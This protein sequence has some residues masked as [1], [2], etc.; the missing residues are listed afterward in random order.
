[1]RSLMRVGLPVA[2][3]RV[4]TPQPKGGACEGSAETLLRFLFSGESGMVVGSFSILGHRM[5]EARG[6]SS[7]TRGSAAR[8]YHFFAGTHAIPKTAPAP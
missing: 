4:G 5:R 2:V 1:M 6:S 3:L 7:R 8:P